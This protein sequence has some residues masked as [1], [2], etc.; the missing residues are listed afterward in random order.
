MLVGDTPVGKQGD[1]NGQREKLTH[2]VVVTE[3][4]ADLMGSL[5]A[6]M[7]TQV[8]PKLRP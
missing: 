4:S 5:G 2:N 3:A 7:A 1:R 6:E 8:C